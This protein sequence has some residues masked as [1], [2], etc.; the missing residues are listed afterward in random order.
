LHGSSRDHHHGHNHAHAHSPARFDRA[1]AIGTALNAGFVVVELVFGVAANSMAL[2]ADAGHNLTDVAGLLLAWGAATV[3]RK[4]PFGRFTYGL[5]SATILAALASS[6]ILMLAVGGIVWEAVGRLAKPE[7]AGGLTIMAVAAV[8]LAI[9]TATALMFLSGRNDVAA[10]IVVGTW[11]LLHDSLSSALHAVP[12]GID[13]AA[14]RR[15]LEALPGVES[16]HDLHI[17]PISTTETALTCHLVMPG[18]HP[19]DRFLAEAAEMM[20]H[21]FA[22]NHVTLQIET[23]DGA[24]CVLRPDEVV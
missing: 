21:G 1:F 20:L 23:S 3:A 17:W 16:V 2:L 24:N 5:R 18:G 19:G 15:R 12:K 13:L 9:N 6:L 4:P 10:V 14:V 11:S 7:P 8:G 22:I